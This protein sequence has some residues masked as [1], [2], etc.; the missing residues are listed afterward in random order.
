MALVILET[1]AGL[2]IAIIE[3]G[4][5]EAPKEAVAVKCIAKSMRAGW[6]G[7]TVVM[8][9][10]ERIVGDRVTDM[11]IVF[12]PLFVY[13]NGHQDVVITRTVGR[14]DDGLEST[15]EIV[16]WGKWE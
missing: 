3:V 10:V 12:K 9:E 8:A 11:S 5:V 14:I 4:I 7:T 13:C 1:S 16:I 15:A 2:M 6:M